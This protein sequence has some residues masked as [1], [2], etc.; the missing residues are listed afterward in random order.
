MH[1]I[2]RPIFNI[3][4]CECCGTIFQPETGDVLCYRFKTEVPWE[5][6]Q[7]YTHCPTCGTYCE[8]TVAGDTRED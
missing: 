8:V 1:I 5:V 6:D 4:K 3:I 2:K 7:I